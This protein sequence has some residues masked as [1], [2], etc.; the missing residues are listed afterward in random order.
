METPLRSFFAGCDS[1]TTLQLKQSNDRFIYDFLDPKTFSL[2]SVLGEFVWWELP[3]H[4]GST[5]GL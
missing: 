5:S 1:P 2:V 3:S 4:G